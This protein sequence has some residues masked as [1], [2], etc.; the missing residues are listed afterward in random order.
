VKR[1]G[2]EEKEVERARE[3]EAAAAA[4]K[5]THTKEKNQCFIHL[6]ALDIKST[7]LPASQTLRHSPPDR[8]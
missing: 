2:G 4:S 1:E 3:G 6:L 8:A 7:S 5:S